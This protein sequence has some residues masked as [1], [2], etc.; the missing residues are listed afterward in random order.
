MEERRGVPARVRRVS[1]EL[2]EL[3]GRTGLSAAEVSQSLGISMS[4]LSRMETG[5]R[6]LAADDVSALLGLYRVPARRRE[7]ILALVRNGGDRNWWQV[8]DAALPAL[9]QDL[10]RFEEEAT[11]LHSWETQFVP[12]LLQTDE[13]AEAVIRGTTHELPEH[14]IERLVSA[15]IGRQAVLLGAHAPRLEVLLDEPVL[16]R[17][18]AEPGVMR[19]QLLRLAE[20]NRRPNVTVRVVPLSAGI[21]PGMEGPFVLLEYGQQPNL[22]YLEHRGNSAFLEEPEHVAATGRSLRWLRELALSPDDSSEI[23]ARS[24]DDPAISEGASTWTP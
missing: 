9:W 2:R 20:S 12:G 3:R 18:T 6:G 10:M 21:H 5:A 15:R 14:E 7:E 8:Q 24:A 23:I 16:R 1:G 4:K 11:A 13:Y 19:R 17:P 22:V